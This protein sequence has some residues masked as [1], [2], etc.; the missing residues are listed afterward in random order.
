MRTAPS[1]SSSLNTPQS[2]GTK[3]ATICR[4]VNAAIITAVALYCL[5]IPGVTIIWSMRDPG[6]RDGSMPRLAFRWHRS[7]TPK[8][9]QWARQRVAAGTA[10]NK[11]INDISGTEWPVFGS[12]F[13]LWATDSLQT[14]WQ[15]DHSLASE[16]PADYARDAIEAAAALVVDPGHAA[17][18]KRHWGDD[19]LHEENVFYRELVIAA[20]TCHARL[21]GSTQYLPMLRDQVETFAEALDRSPH[22]LLNDYPGQCYP[23][24]VLGAIAAIRRAD[25]ILGTDHSAFVRRAMRAFEGPLLDPVGLPP[26][27]ADPLGGQVIGRSRGC[28]NSFM[29]IWAPELWP[30]RAADWYARYEQHF[31]QERWT[32]VGF[33]EFPKDM[34]LGDWYRDV[35]AGPV[36]AGHGIAACAFGVGAA[37]ANGRLDHAYGL[38]AEMLVTS[39]PLPDG[40]LAGPR[41]LSNAVDAPYLGEAGVLFALTRCPTQGVPIRVG[42]QLPGFYYLV[43]GIGLGIGLILLAGTLRGVR[44]WRRQPPEVPLPT[45]QATFWTMLMVG[46]IVTCLVWTTVGGAAMI[47]AAQLLPRARRR[48]PV[49]IKPAVASDVPVA[50]AP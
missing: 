18:V 36:L 47:L 32:A 5:V 10:A 26:Y 37:R 28:G 27:A 2:T 3:I 17:W 34:P 19:Y 29:L 4:Y 50:P 9:E 33:R 41:V 48:K 11:S 23:T 30:E 43:L 25:A 12:V 14:A 6:L 15:A 21:T 39:W 38:T 35:D 22:G 13:Y 44:R 46:G 7:L 1:E 42:H 20:L 24:D 8:Y 31:W 16:A 49:E 40:T 45:L